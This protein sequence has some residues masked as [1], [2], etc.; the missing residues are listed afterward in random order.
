[1][2]IPG[3]HAAPILGALTRAVQEL[4]KKMRKQAAEGAAAGLV[5]N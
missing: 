3:N 2:L 1:L 4:D 5:S